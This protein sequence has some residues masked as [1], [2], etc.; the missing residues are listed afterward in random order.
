VGLGSDES[1]SAPK[2]E[3]VI[4]KVWKTAA[5]LTFLALA[6]A[7]SSAPEPESSPPVPPSSGAFS[8]GQGSAPPPSA[9][10]A[11]S[12]GTLPI[13][14]VDRSG[15]PGPAP[16]AAQPLTWQVPAG[17]TE[18]KPENNIRLAQYRVPGSAG[19][20]ECV[21]F[22]FGPGQGGDAESNARRW[23]GQFTQ[24]DG[25]P[26][27]DLMKMEHLD[28]PPGHYHV[29]EVT[30]TFQ[31]GMN[32]TESLTGYMLLGGIIDG[33][34]APWFFKLIGPEATIRENRA[35]FIEMMESIRK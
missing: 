32:G 27:T 8:P 25:R 5:A 7:C 16:A 35:V 1:Q 15:N 26:S 10:A 9:P 34:D 28:G 4:S 11:P 12:A 17:W 23:A 19:D 22:Y 31:G 14:G 21:V 6:A 3:N 13:P 33:A 29:V 30:G 18:E 20:G 24:P 2:G